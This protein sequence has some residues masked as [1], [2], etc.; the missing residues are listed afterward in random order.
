MERW[1]IQS[2]MISVF[3]FLK[4]FRPEDPYII[5]YLTSSPMNFTIE[6]IIQEIFPVSTYTCVNVTIII[7]LVTDYLHYKPILVFGAISSVISQI[8]LIFAR[9]KTNMQIMDFFDGI[10]IA[11]DIP[12]YTYIYTAVDKKHY[13]I[14]SSHMNM[15]CLI[16]R[17]SSA[18]LAQ[19]LIDNHILKVQH[20]NYLTLTGT[21]LS[22]LWAIGLPSV[23]KSLYFHQG[24]EKKKKITDIDTSKPKN[25]FQIL[26]LDFITAFTNHNVLQWSI[27]WILGTYFYYQFMSY[28]Q[29]LY[30][31]IYYDGTDLQI[32]NNGMVEA[33]YTITSTL[34]VYFV[35]IIRIPSWWLVG[36]LTLCQ[37]LILMVM[38]Q[39]HLLSY[40]YLGYILFGTFYHIMITIANCEVA[41]NIP[42]DCYALVFG[43]NTFTSHLLQT[44]VTIVVNSPIGLMLN[45]RTQF[46][47]YGLS[48]L[49]IGFV[50]TINALRS[51]IS[52]TRI[53]DI[54]TIA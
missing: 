41:K 31:Q 46:Y 47:L 12:Y 53:Q 19:T 20:L 15:A 5:Q 1:L 45:I 29:S 24:T 52:R 27:C 34:G 6:E 14:V 30:Q 9:T 28:C 43:I 44:C 26:W 16:G 38:A 51:T 48:Y 35:G 54:F 11:C 42:A 4:D 50:Y 32:T 39:E 10:M 21:T 37:G 18:V 7:F 13:K 25:V 3:G 33:I 49:I 23:Q 40:A 2:I 22:L 8:F 17:F 36:I